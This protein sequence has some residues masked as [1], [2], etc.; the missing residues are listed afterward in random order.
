MLF[1]RPE[2]LGIHRFFAGSGQVNVEQVERVAEALQQHD[3]PVEPRE[4]RDESD[5][6]DTKLMTAINRLEEAGAIDTRFTHATFGDG[7]VQRYEGD[8]VVVLFDDAGYKTLLTD[9]VVESGAL[10]PAE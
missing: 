5:L 2:D 1:Y 6:S 9:F 7:P 3:G 8:K 4:L 10:Q